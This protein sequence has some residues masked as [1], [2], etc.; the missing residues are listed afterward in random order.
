KAV[1]VDET[2]IEDVSFHTANFRVL[3]A[4]DNYMNRQYISELLQK[5]GITHDLAHNGK[6]ALQL[7]SQQPYDLIFMDLQMPFMD[8]IE[9]TRALRTSDGP[10][11]RTPIVALTA[12]ALTSR[13]NEALDAGMNDF[14]P[15]PFSPNQLRQMLN[16]Y[17]IKAGQ[18][19]KAS[20]H[21]HRFH[22]NEALDTNYLE[23][24]YEGDLD[25]AADIFETFLDVTLP[26]FRKLR[27]LAQQ[28]DWTAFRKLA[29][30]LKP[31][32]L[33]VGLSH[34]S[35]R[36]EK[37]E[38]IQ[39][40]AQTPATILGQLDQLEKEVNEYIPVLTS[41]LERMKQTLDMSTPEP[42]PSL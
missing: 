19:M 39:P 7:A 28:A 13:K 42:A 15:K 30:K 25:Y 14:L 32:F 29:H 16:T 11:A 31:N 23:F 18:S 34:L 4:E 9:A 37:L 38:D 6:E 3:I 27:P 8:G 40:D 36:L 41:E 5:W 22:F 2:R 1:A 17:A 21:K 12:S 33:M 10:N 26:E 24:F 35:A 20:D